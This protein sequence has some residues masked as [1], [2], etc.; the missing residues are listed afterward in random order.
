MSLP[1]LPRPSIPPR[2][3]LRLLL[4]IIL[5]TVQFTPLLTPPAAAAPR[6][7]VLQ[8]VGDFLSLGANTVREL[9]QAI[10]LA[11]AEMR[12]TLEALNNDIS[13]LI[14]TLSQTY[15]DN[16][17]V[18]IN[19]LD[20]ATRNKLLELQGLIDQVNE[21]L[22]Q[23]ITLASEAAKDVI[24]QASLQIRRATLEVEQSLKNIIVVGGETA[25]FV[26]DRA[27]YDGIL[28]VC[29]VLL[30]LGLLLFVFLLF[31]QRLPGGLAG[32]LVLLFMGIFLA[33]NGALVFIPPVRAYA[34]TF[35]GVG[36]EQRLE[37][38]AAQPRILDILPDPIVVG[39]TTEVQVWGNTLMPQ[40]TPPSVKIAD[41][42]VAL[43]AV[44]NDQVVVNMSGFDGP[45]GST[46]LVLSYGDREGPREVVRL[47][48]L[49][50][51]PSPP[52]LVI[53]GY[54]IAPASPVQR[55]NARATIVVRN[56][57][58]GPTN[59]SFVVQWKPY[60]A[61]PGLSSTVPTLAAG[62]SQTLTFDFAYPNPGPVDA[63]AIVDVFNT[64]AE[65]NEG[66][67][68]LTRSVAVQP[69]PP[70]R[71]RVG[72]TFTQVTVHDDA[73]PAADGEL[74]LDFN[75]SSQTG[76]FP[77]SGTKDVNS[78]S[79]YSIGKRFELTL[80]ETEKLTIFVNG[81][82]EDN[83][84]F[85]LFD[86]NDPMGTVSKEYVSANEWGRGSHSD[87]S[88]CPDGCYTIHYTIDVTWLQ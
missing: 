59:R 16:L 3:I 64:V 76:R 40:G 15:Q 60:A 49:T 77:N 29:L 33:L 61:H 25:A 51:T 62:Q 12:G 65:T 53:A 87:R 23:D 34:M 6:A 74:W 73:D 48:R 80:S 86:D 11:G 41:R 45:E 85:P 68:S 70:R 47:A 82:D 20:A 30:G 36:L 8:T 63:V 81:T 88:S 84:G 1:V 52:D 83:P 46:N 57:G 42:S 13:T 18:T 31:T 22:Q 79:T 39:R 55:G 72:V 54:S 10:Q 24:R 50:P 28:I 35:T 43:N 78:G 58:A 75:I 7:G 37:K 67:N 69:A 71:A 56:Q 26:V 38:V 4:I 21:T 17:N 44:S 32:K 19:S 14:Q 5:V 2:M 9:Q 27:I 66:N